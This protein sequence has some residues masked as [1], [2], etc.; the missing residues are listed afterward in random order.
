MSD[1]GEYRGYDTLHCCACSNGEISRGFDTQ[2]Y[3]NA[4]MSWARVFDCGVCVTRFDSDFA[5]RQ[6]NYAFLEFSSP[7]PVKLEGDRVKD[8]E[9]ES[10]QIIL[11]AT[12]FISLPNLR[13]LSKIYSQAGAVID[14]GLYLNTFHPSSYPSLWSSKQSRIH[15]W[16]VGQATKDLFRPNLFVLVGLQTRLVGSGW[17]CC[18]CDDEQ[19]FMQVGDIANVGVDGVVHVVMNRFRIEV[20]AY[21]S[22][23]IGILDP[24]IALGI[25]AP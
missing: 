24:G 18:V 17:D 9:N 15:T 21:L 16:I 7:N 11:G 14:F 3:T 19:H 1:K 25:G 20:P 2:T 8:T 12:W 6:R 10:R 13:I 23:D 4:H 22:F 5:V